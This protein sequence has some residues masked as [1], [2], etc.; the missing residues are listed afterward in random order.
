MDVRLVM[1]PGTPGSRTIQLRHAET[2]VGRRRDCGVRVVARE[3]SRRHCL[4]SFQDGYVS[5]QDLDSINGTYLNGRRIVGRQVVRPG[6]HL[7]VGPAI[8]RVEY[9]LT[10]EGMKR[11]AEATAPGEE[12]VIEADLV[13]ANVEEVQ[14]VEL[15]DDTNQPLPVEPEPAEHGV[16]KFDER[17]DA[18]PWQLPEPDKLH[19]ILTKMD[20]APS[21]EPRRAR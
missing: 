1:E 14:E 18:R 8:F 5:V 21:G 20:D 17:D 10:Q 3:V 4:V 12:E 6:D 11:I 19:D 7:E 2:V 9:E 16:F 13:P 15:V